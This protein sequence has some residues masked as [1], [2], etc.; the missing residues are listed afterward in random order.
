[1]QRFEDTRTREQTRT[2][3][4]KCAR[5]SGLLCGVVCALCAVKRP[6]RGAKTAAAA[7][8]AQSVRRAQA[9]TRQRQRH[10]ETEWHRANANANTNARVRRRGSSVVFHS[11]WRARGESD[12]HRRQRNATRRAAMQHEQTCNAAAAELLVEHLRKHVNEHSTS[13]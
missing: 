6:S 5:R 11:V 10:D 3:S 13:L 2:T 1:M 4:R 9:Q 7:A 12:T 8:A